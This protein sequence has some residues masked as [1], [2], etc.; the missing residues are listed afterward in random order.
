MPLAFSKADLH[1][2]GALS[3]SKE[4]AAG[5]R[6]L[7]NG[8]HPLFRFSYFNDLPD[9]PTH[10]AMS[11]AEWQ[12]LIPAWRL[13]TKL[14]TELAC[15]SWWCTLVLGK[16]R[17]EFCH[18]EHSEREVLTHVEA[19]PET[20]RAVRKTFLDLSNGAVRDAFCDVN[21]TPT[22]GPKPARWA[23]T[24]S[25]SKRP[26]IEIRLNHGTLLFNKNHHPLSR[27]RFWFILAEIIVHELTHAVSQVKRRSIDLPTARSITRI[28][29][30]TYEPFYRADDA[31]AE[32]G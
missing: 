18:P 21:A 7:T 19:T 1:A 15:L 24:Q 10:I 17:R 29:N 28:E 26:V 6:M 2:E 8:I 5:F 14:I 27:L 4:T 9:D 12:W 13:A 25:T 22:A 20:L 3:P 16:I 11:L 31:M 23:Y 30:Q 32:L